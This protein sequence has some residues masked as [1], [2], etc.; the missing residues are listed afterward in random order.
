MTTPVRLPEPLQ[1]AV[2]E[3][4]LRHA[5]E[6]GVAAHEQ[7]L[8]PDLETALRA[9]HAEPPRPFER[10]G[11]SLDPQQVKTLTIDALRLAHL[12]WLRESGEA[13]GAAR[14][15][16]RQRVGG[17]VAV[18]SGA[19]LS[20]D[21]GFPT[22]RGAAGE[23]LWDQV[24][25]MVLASVA[26]YRE[27]PQRSMRWYCHRRSLGLPAVPTLAHAAIAVAQD[28]NDSGWAG[29]HTQNVDGLHEVAG[30]R[31][32]NR[33]HGSIWVWKD[34]VDEQLVF[35]PSDDLDDVPLG[36]DRRPRWRPGV[37]MFGDFAPTGIYARATH[38]LLRAD[39]A[40]VV[41]TSAQV[42]TLWPLLDAAYQGGAL[43]VEI[44]PEAS[45]VTL[46]L[47]ATHLPLPAG[48]GVPLALEELGALDADTT[49]RLARTPREP[50]RTVIHRLGPELTR[51]A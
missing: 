20:V 31:G 14:A 4:L 49:D 1:T 47:G 37:V 16:L 41:G 50:L 18:L 39:V 17:R 24:D 28:R 30:S 36:D 38:Q 21:A 48:V 32:V 5:G 46:E 33:I 34:L 3:Q 35:D 6:L 51:D 19:G 2:L 23:G 42:S 22:F 43:L 15:E 25:P 26:G 29:V 13:F 27:D 11:L 10:D 12:K 45:P 8:P 7:H 40:L 44:N 9:W